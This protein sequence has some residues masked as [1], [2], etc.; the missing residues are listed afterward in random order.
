[1]TGNGHGGAAHAGR[2]RIFVTGPN[3]LVDP[4]LGRLAPRDFDTESIEALVHHPDVC[5]KDLSLALMEV[6]A[7]LGRLRAA[8][9]EAARQL[10]GVAAEIKAASTID[11]RVWPEE[12]AE[13]QGEHDHLLQ[14]ADRLT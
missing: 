2:P 8:A 6:V 3:L 7:E 12:E 14:L 11:G 13:A 4:A 9:S 1:M 10:Q 5:A